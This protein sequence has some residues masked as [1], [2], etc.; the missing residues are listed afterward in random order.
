MPLPST[1]KLYTLIDT[2]YLHGRSPELVTQQLCDG[3]SDLIQLRAKQSSPSG[4]R[5]LPDK[6]LSIT[7]RSAIPLIINDHPSITSALSTIHSSLSPLLGCHLGQEDFFDS[8]SGL[9]TVNS[10][11][12]IPKSSLSTP[13]SGLSTINS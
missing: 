3:G 2:A 4:I 13:P 5:E 8:P 9:S 7:S 6:L 1:C 11:P 10:Q 12:S